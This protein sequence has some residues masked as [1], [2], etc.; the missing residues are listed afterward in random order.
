MRLL[1]MRVACRQIRRNSRDGR[2]LNEFG[3][4]DE[5]TVSGCELW[6]AEIPRYSGD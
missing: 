1:K 4:I 5:E 3:T 6:H 2:A